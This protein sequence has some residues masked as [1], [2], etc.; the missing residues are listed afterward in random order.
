MWTQKTTIY[1][2]KE[3]VPPTPWP[4]TLSLQNILLG[5][6]SPSLWV[7]PYGRLNSIHCM[8]EMW[9]KGL[10]F[11]WK[12]LLGKST[13][14]LVSIAKA[15]IRKSQK[16]GWMRFLACELSLCLQRHYLFLACPLGFSSGGSSMMSW[17]DWAWSKLFG[18]FGEHWVSN[19]N[20]WR[21]IQRDSSEAHVANS[22]DSLLVALGK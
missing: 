2:P 12:P 13:M 11:L 7:V 9:L 10:A 4:L 17:Q 1:K 16:W 8:C 3:E 15:W 21:R 6:Q 19:I 18:V 20:T 5:C 14:L 22:T